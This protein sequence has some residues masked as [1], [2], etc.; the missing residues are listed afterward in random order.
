M[1]CLCALDIEC[2]FD[3]MKKNGDGRQAF[4]KIL[5]NSLFGKFGSKDRKRRIEG[6]EE[7]EKILEHDNWRDEYELKG[8]TKEAE[9]G[10]YLMEKVGTVKPQCNFFPLASAIT[11]Y[12]RVELQR[13]ISKCQKIR[14]A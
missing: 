6:K 12:A 8:W 10:F 14:V 13:T 7:I 5:L 2:A 1:C 4:C 3:K 9:D 11:S